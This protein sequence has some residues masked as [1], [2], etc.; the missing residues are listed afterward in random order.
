[1]PQTSRKKQE[2][3]CS[4]T[5]SGRW[6][7]L[8]HGLQVSSV[9]FHHNHMVLW[10]TFRDSSFANE[11]PFEFKQ[12]TR[13]IIDLY[14]NNNAD[15]ILRDKGTFRGYWKQCITVVDP[16]LAARRNAVFYDTQGLSLPYY[17][18]CNFLIEPTCNIYPC[19]PAD[20]L[21]CRISRRQ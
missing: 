6:Y 9:R 11:T 13:T 4:G 15:E 20:I 2:T 19:I 16:A 3:S 17:H 18:L 1:M 21:D 10:T 5:Q 8:S 7:T 14:F 12:F